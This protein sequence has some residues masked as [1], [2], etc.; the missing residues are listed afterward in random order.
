M[1]TINPS[2]ARVNPP[3]IT[4]T[5]HQQ[6]NNADSCLKPQHGTAMS[7]DHYFQRLLVETTQNG[8]ANPHNYNQNHNHHHHHNHHKSN[9]K[10]R[11]FSNVEATNDMTHIKQSDSISSSTKISERHKQVESNIQSLLEL[12]GEQDMDSDTDFSDLSTWVMNVNNG[13][14]PKSR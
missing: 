7:F 14:M 2:M 4:G 5:T 6:S 9:N 10:S 8:Q 3:S 1:Q 11:S 12:I 13:M